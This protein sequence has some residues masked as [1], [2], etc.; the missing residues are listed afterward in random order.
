MPDTRIHAERDGE[1]HR[2]LHIPDDDLA[3]M[4]ELLGRDLEEE[5]VVD[6]DARQTAGRS[7]SLT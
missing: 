6:L 7:T 4:V 1:I 2:A 3:E 5:F